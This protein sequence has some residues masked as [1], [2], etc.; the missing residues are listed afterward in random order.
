MAEQPKVSVILPVWNGERYVSQAVESILSQT[1][2]DFELVIVD[3]GSDDRTREVLKPYLRLGRITYHRQPHLGVAMAMNTAIAMAAGEYIAIQDHD[4]LSLPTRLEHEVEVLDTYPEHALVYSS[5]LHLDDN[6]EP[7]MRWGGKGRQLSQQQA[8][9]ELYLQGPFIPNPSI[10]MR[11]SLLRPEPPYC[12]ELQVAQDYE[13]QL[14]L[15]HDHSIYEYLSPLVK[16]RRGQNHQSLT[17][18]KELNYKT[19]R[20]ILAMIHRRYKDAQPRITKLDYVRALS[21]QLWR[22]GHQWRRDGDLPKAL[23]RFLASSLVNPLNH[24]AWASTGHHSVSLAASLL[25]R[26]A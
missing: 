9:Y 20:R 16:M 11:A 18:K 15:T 13:H 10:M 8:F 19:E 21:N 26:D 12:A 5:V 17:S 1:F 14:R 2:Q 24:R 23:R 22:E 25:R 7:V 3:D 4:D 6:D